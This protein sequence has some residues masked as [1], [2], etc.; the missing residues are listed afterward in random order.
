MIQRYEAS[1]N[2][3]CPASGEKEHE[4]HASSGDEDVPQTTPVERP[5]PP[6]GA[7]KDNDRKRPCA[8]LQVCWENFQ[9]TCPRSYSLV[10][11]VLIPIVLLIGL[12]FLGGYLVAL[13]ESDDEI[14]KNDANIADFINFVIALSVFS[15]KLGETETTT[16]FEDIGE[17]PELC[18]MN[19]DTDHSN[20]TRFFQEL[21]ECGLSLLVQRGEFGGLSFEWITCGEEMDRE[22]QAEHVIADWID[23]YV[24]HRNSSINAT[25]EA[26]HMADTSEHLIEDWIDSY[27]VHLNSTI[28]TTNE[29]IFTAAASTATGSK[30]C[31]VH[32]AAG[33]LFFFLIMTTVGYGSTAPVTDAGRAL[34]F[35]LGFVSILCFTSLIS[36]A[37]SIC[38]AVFDDFALRIGAERLAR[39][40]WAALFWLVMLTVWLLILAAV[41]DSAR[42]GKY[43]FAGLTSFHD[44][45]WFSY[46]TITTVGLGDYHIPHETITV[47]NMFYIPV[48]L[49]FGFVLLANFLHKFS[50]ALR[51]FFPQGRSLEEVLEERR[52]KRT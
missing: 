34:V 48:L 26:M 49:M 23:S 12:S 8:S 9:E 50:V 37:G 31:S 44:E 10:F 22:S 3:R 30:D 14:A 11:K 17:I 27:A 36:R 2:P 29:A 7:E 5:V 16:E 4:S 13:V 20:T 1:D 18:I 25:S 35:T 45:F 41:A 42:H 51:E 19:I 32:V 40:A 21:L 33:A 15:G 46:I 24:E 28:N 39:G 52:K 47:G 6:G 43:G 38:L